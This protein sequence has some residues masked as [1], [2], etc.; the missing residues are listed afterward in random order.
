MAKN[1]SA[2][3]ATLQRRI[4]EYMGKDGFIWKARGDPRQTKGIPDVCG[5]YHG[6]F[7]YWEVKMPGRE[8]TLTKN[9]AEVIKRLDNAGAVGAVVTNW[10]ETLRVL[11]E[12]E[13]RLADLSG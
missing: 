2:L 6:F 7:V 8:K 3:T 13:E 9:Q 5:V 12:V 1:E 4:K 11:T 10:K